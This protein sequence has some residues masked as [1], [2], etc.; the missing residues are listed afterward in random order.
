MTGEGEVW[1]PTPEPPAT[2][3]GGV[4]EATRAR[5]DR[6]HSVFWKVAGVLVGV[7]VAT[8]LL[9]VGLSAWFALDRGLDLAANSLRLRLDDLAEEIEQRAAP[10]DDGLAGLPPLLYLDLARRFPDPIYLL[11]ADGTVLRVVLPDPDEFPEARPAPADASPPPPG[12]DS[13]LAAGDVVVRLDPDEP[14]GT[15]ALAPVYAPDGLLVGGLLVQPLTNALARELAGTRTAFARAMIAVAL[16]AVVLALLL[17]AIFT[18]RLVRPLRRMTARVERIGAGD[19]GTRLPADGRDEFARLAAA[20]NRMAAEVEQSMAVLRETDRLRRQLIANVGHDLRTPLAALQGYLEEAERHLASGRPEAARE[21][22]ATAARQGRY[23]HRLVSDLFELSQLDQ[24][25]AP[26]R[27]EPIPLA[28]LLTDAARAHRA[29][30]EQAGIRFDLDLPRDLPL[31][32]A[33]GV[34]LLRVLDNLLANARRH[35]PPGGA[36]RL[37]ATAEPDRVHI[38][39]ID[40]GEGLTPEEQAHVFERY[41]RGRHARTR[42][43]GGTGLGLAISHAIA[44]AH[45][46]DLSVTSTPGAGS[47]FRLTLPREEA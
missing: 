17:G 32:E 10:L 18:D 6:W 38:D 43:A 3:A 21:A 7:Q 12:L 27:R 1:R 45:G 41:Y 16:L 46:G 2:P 8:G 22:L 33:D 25:P 15:W 42:G 23:L 28:E 24:I 20:I 39:V 31:L 35:T 47:T 40:T 26:L 13:L 4:P 19:Y 29:A 36:V 11:G 37:R 14:G 5:P 30:F 34:R 44:R 9:A